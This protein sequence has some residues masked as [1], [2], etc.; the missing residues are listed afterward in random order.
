MWTPSGA[1]LV[2]RERER[3]GCPSG[4][5][6]CQAMARKGV[7]GRCTPSCT[8][9][10]TKLNEEAVND[11]LYLS[12]SLDPSIVSQQT[13]LSLIGSNPLKEGGCGNGLDHKS[14]SL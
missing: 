2:L 14:A 3:G 4:S 6:A 9:K 5:H 10:N 8:E 12:T 7:G 11:V 1:D 13:I